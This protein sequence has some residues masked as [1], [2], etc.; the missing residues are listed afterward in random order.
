MNKKLLLFLTGLFLP[1]FPLLSHAQSRNYFTDRLIIKYESDVTLSQLR[2]KTGTDPRAAV[3]QM[4][5]KNG[6][7]TE[8]S[9]FSE[10]L[11]RQ[12]QQANRAPVRQLLQIQEATFSRIIDP[13]LLAAKIS[14]M[15]GVAYAEPKYIHRLF[16]T[17]SD[18]VIEKFVSAHDFTGAWDLSKGSS[19]VVIAIV[20]GGVNY[21]H[22]DLDDKLWINQN[23]VP[24]TLRP[25][26]DENSDGEITST[27][28]KHYLYQNGSDYNGDGE[29]ALDDALAPNSGFTD[30]LDNDNNGFTDDLFG[31][32][33]WDAGPITAPTTD[34]N[35]ILDGT[36]HG[37]HVAG[38]A[39][40]ETDNDSSVAGAGFNSLYMAVKAGGTAQDPESVGYGFEGIL[41][42]AEQ[43]ADIISCSW[44]GSA[45]SQAE[46]DVINAV[47][48]M[49]SLVVAAAGNETIDQ[50][51]YP[52]A[53]DKVISVGS[54]ET[55]NA[56]ASYSNY[57][58]KLDVLA[59]GSG[60]RSTSYSDTLVVKSGTSMAT[61]VVSGLAAL[62]KDIHPGWSAE[63]IGTQIRASSQYIYSAN[64]INYNHKLGHG[65]IDAF[66][67]LDTNLPGLKVIAHRFENA[68]GNKL[69][70]GEPGSLILS[71]VNVGNTTSSLTLQ[72]QTLNNG[73]VQLGSNSQQLGSVATG[74][75]VQVSFPLTI[76]DDFD[77]SQVPTFRLSFRD[78]NLNYDDFN[79]I[80]YTNFLFD[81]IA[82]NNVKTSI[83]SDGTIGFTDPISGLGGVGFIPRSPNG[84]GG[85]QEGD[86]LL[87][88]GGLIMEIN[89]KIY[90]AA[91]T[92]NGQ[93]SRDF[94]P[95]QV[96][97]VKTPGNVS[98]SDG[99]ASFTIGPD[100]TQN[101]EITLDTYAFD[102]ATL[103]NVVYLKY[104]IQNRSTVNVVKDLYVGLFNDWDV[105]S[106]AS[107]NSISY[108]ESDSVLYISDATAGSSQPLVAVAQLGPISSVLAIDNA[109]E[110]EQDS[111]TFGL[112]DG[113]SDT[114]K[115]NSLHARK[116]RTTIQNTDVSAVNASGPYTLNPGA[117]ITVGFVYAFGSDLS[118]LGSQIS[119]ARSQSPFAVSPT[120]RAVSAEV[121]KQTKLYQNYP[122]PFNPSTE[123]RFDLEQDSDVELVIF[124]VLG[125]KVRTLINRKLQANSYFIE[126]NARNLSSGV[127]FARLK[128]ENGIETIPMTLIK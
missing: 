106:D 89:G 116:V 41:Y 9:L 26:V 84:T 69:S 74:D 25:Q 24:V 54:V 101:M 14:K 100:T 76:T 28:I 110:G 113:F 96:F 22:P 20:D 90:D 33:F 4:L 118:E 5:Q 61:P 42:A 45:F 29:I 126:F 73:A 13:V 38:I 40:A 66:R 57:G 10:R 68:D 63:R 109:V 36:D 16:Y 91:R 104:T 115:R 31:W 78:N 59:T 1:I 2:S 47:T 99:K 88:E 65:A 15:P 23:E 120:G 8:H 85:Y 117:K 103:S 86:N 12:F 124:D 53:Y 75:T 44:G 71:L 30:N 111:V 98:D 3:R 58:Y 56:I 125:R 112:Y 127:Y 7:R 83:A 46:Q 27:E 107:Q 87:F 60:I 48:D 17:P 128:T 81:V 72:L 49:G 108:S 21:L 51:S 43:G 62:I 114:E 102:K 121:P 92:S 95:Q 11:R 105:G 6:M 80:R 52:A 77:L 67:A 55:S 34:N 37:T 39:A 50:V 64:P 94:D 35:P 119:E 97:S 70:L 82:A 18:P 122:N 93:V 123:I 19:D 32:D 79:I